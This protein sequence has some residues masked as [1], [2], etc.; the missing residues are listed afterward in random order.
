MAVIRPSQIDGAHA[1]RRARVWAKKVSRVEQ[2]NLSARGGYALDGPFVRWTEA[3]ALHPGE[4]LV[5]SGPAK[6]TLA[7]TR[8][9]ET[10]EAVPWDEI[11]QLVGEGGL[12]DEVAAQAQNNQAYKLAAYLWLRYRTAQPGEPEAQAP[13]PAA[14]SELEQLYA[15]IRE[16][17]ERDQLE[18]R[19]RLLQDL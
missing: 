7:T 4:Y 15:R 14:S 6:W 5:L 10:V 11:T 16:L 8:D 3:V 9:G 13:M 2:I 19:N 18:L 17:P 1:G 12:P